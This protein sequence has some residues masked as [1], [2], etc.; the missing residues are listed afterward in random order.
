MYMIPHWLPSQH[1]IKVLDPGVLE[2]HIAHIIY[3]MNKILFSDEGIICG[4]LMSVSTL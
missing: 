2:T 3:N 4:K 1:Y